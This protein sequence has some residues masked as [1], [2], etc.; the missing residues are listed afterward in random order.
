MTDTEITVINCNDVTDQEIVNKIF[1]IIVFL[2]KLAQ[3]SL[4]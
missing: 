3:T 2:S 4:S 1:L